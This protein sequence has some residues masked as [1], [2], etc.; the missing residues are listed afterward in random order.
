MLSAQPG[1]S[2]SPWMQGRL[3]WIRKQRGLLLRSQEV[4]LSRV[5]WAGT[6]DDTANTANCGLGCS[7]RC[8]GLACMEQEPCTCVQR[9]S[10]VVVR[11]LHKHT[12][13]AELTLLVHNPPLRMLTNR[14]V[15][16]S[17]PLFPSHYTGL[18]PASKDSRLGICQG[19]CDTDRDCNEVYAASSNPITGV[20]VDGVKVPF[21]AK[22]VSARDGAVFRAT[23]EF[24]A[25]TRVLAIAG[26]ARGT[27]S[28]F[29]TGG[30]AMT[31]GSTPG[32][33]TPWNG[34]HTGASH[35]SKWRAR[36]RA[37]RRAGDFDK[38]DADAKINYFDFGQA[39]WGAPDFDASRW[40]VLAT[41]VLRP[42]VCSGCFVPQHDLPCMHVSGSETGSFWP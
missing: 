15:D 10:T 40:P 1:A 32:S 14:N 25:S 42:S 37:A 12:R 36:G 11:W 34:A 29:D 41:A 33:R 5:L 26:R 22:K 4:L 24:P 6:A 19:D 9:R 13:I 3:F 35:G 30:F 17:A 21:H 20:Y 39:P 2:L 8:F 27:T 16:P 7:A 28:L 23:V 18:S 31:C 38:F